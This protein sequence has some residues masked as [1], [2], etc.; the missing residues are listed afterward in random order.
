MGRKNTICVLV[1]YMGRQFDKFWR[2]AEY[3]MKSPYDIWTGMRRTSQRRRR[4]LCKSSL[5]QPRRILW[6]HDWQYII[7]HPSCI[8]VQALCRAFTT[9]RP[10]LRGSCYNHASSI[11]TCPTTAPMLRSWF[12]KLW[13]IC[14]TLVK[15]FRLH[16][17]IF[18][19]VAP[20]IH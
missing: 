14:T 2:K 19:P 5:K 10:N 13:R 6:D 4:L 7:L 15:A 12:W 17:W 8:L 3:I 1:L 11:H 20:F 16:C 9:Q 18:Q